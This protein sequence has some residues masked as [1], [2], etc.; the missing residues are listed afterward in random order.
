MA[1]VVV[2]MQRIGPPITG[3]TACGDQDAAD[4]FAREISARGGR[5]KITHVEPVTGT[6]P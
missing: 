3:R 1:G 2:P 4:R 5:V 6:A